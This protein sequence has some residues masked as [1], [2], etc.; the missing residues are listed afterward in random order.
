M[1]R[2]SWILIRIWSVG[3]VRLHP[4]SFLRFF[5]NIFKREL[6][7]F[8]AGKDFV[9]GN[10]RDGKR[11]QFK[12][13]HLFICFEIRFGQRQSQQIAEKHIDRKSPSLK[14]EIV[15]VLPNLVRCKYRQGLSFEG[16]Q[17]N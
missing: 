14:V 11:R 9:V 4:S 6:A 7:Q 1:K 13:E 12:P 3:G 16:S 17:V 5:S 2:V 10:V 15:A 8:T